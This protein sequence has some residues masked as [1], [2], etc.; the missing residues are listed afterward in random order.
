MSVWFFCCSLLLP[1]LIVSPSWFKPCDGVYKNVNGLNWQHKFC[2]RFHFSMLVGSNQL[3]YT[4][5][6]YNQSASQLRGSHNDNL[7]SLGKNR[8]TDSCKFDRSFPTHRFSVSVYH[9]HRL[10]TLQLDNTHLVCSLTQYIR[11]ELFDFHYD[12]CRRVLSLKAMS[13]CRFVLTE[14]GGQAIGFSRKA[15]C[16][17]R[18]EDS[19]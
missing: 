14:Y 15:L 17:W 6:W 3:S 7:I 19:R 18:S 9:E 13:T 16:L 8:R 5:R 2:S 4:S 11:Y 12:V 10:G 1:V